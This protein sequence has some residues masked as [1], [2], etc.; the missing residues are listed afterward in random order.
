[1]KKIDSPLVILRS[2]PQ[3]LKLRRRYYNT[4]HINA[5][6]YE[7]IINQKLGQ[8]RKI[9]SIPRNIQLFISNHDEYTVTSKD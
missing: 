1:M 9:G 4:V 5:K 6:S 3:K 7:A 2:K 8:P